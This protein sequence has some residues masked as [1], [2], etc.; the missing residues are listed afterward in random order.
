ML[1]GLVGWA[2][3]RSLWVLFINTGACNACDIEVLAALSPATTR[4]V[5]GYSSRAA[6]ATL[7]SCL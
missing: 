3:S 5:S 7:T 4:S 1:A 2:R 6:R